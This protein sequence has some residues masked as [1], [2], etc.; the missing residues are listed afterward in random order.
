LVSR[1]RQRVMYNTYMNA[2]R[3]LNL[4]RP[5]PVGTSLLSTWERAE[6][7]ASHGMLDLSVGQPAASLL[8]TGLLQ[9]GLTAISADLASGGDPR[10]ALQY[11]SLTGSAGHRAALAAFLA[12]QRGFEVPAASLLLTRGVSHGAHLVARSICPS[13]CTLLME[14]PSYFLM[15]PIFRELNINLVSVPQHSAGEA[16]TSRTLDLDA[17]EQSLD[18]IRPAP[19]LLYLVPTGNNPT[20]RS[21]GDAD[22]RRLVG[23]CAKYGTLILSGAARLIQ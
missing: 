3:Q 20:G 15:H 2:S 7:A 14:N 1:R 11:G 18:T 21:M 8:S 13:G 9:Q 17:L 4:R 19:K 22:R 10:F 16:D 12:Q 23:L 5:A 6:H